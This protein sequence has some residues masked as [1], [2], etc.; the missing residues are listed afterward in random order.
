MSVT[1]TRL[2]PEFLDTNH[3]KPD[4]LGHGPLSDT[5]PFDE[6]MEGVVAAEKD[7]EHEGQKRGVGVNLTAGF[8]ESK[9]VRYK[10]TRQQTLVVLNLFGDVP[11][12]AAKC[13][14]VDS[15]A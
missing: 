5:E 10:R 14:F 15:V 2:S 13:V 1:T 6:L 8:E 7:A 11:D 12:H 4:S 3:L 9:R